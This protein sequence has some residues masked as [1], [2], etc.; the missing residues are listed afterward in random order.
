MSAVSSV[1][2]LKPLPITA[3]GWCARLHANDVSEA[4]RAAF[5]TWVAAST[6]NRAEYELCALTFGVARALPASR[7][8]Y[9][10]AIAASLV[11]VAIGAALAIWHL[12]TIQYATDVG[13]H[14]TI[15][16]ADGSTV[17]L[18]T[19][20]AIGVQLS[21]LQR[22]VT[23]RRGEAFFS[24]VPDSARPFVVQA[25]AS[26]VRVLGTRFNV[27]MEGETARV[28]VIE[29]HVKVSNVDLLPGEGVVTM[30]AR[31][32]TKL[33]EANAAKLTSWREGK[34][35]FE[36]D[37]LAKVIGEVNRYSDIQFV[38]P[39]EKVRALTLSGVFRTGDI[40]SVAFALEESYG[41]KTE[42]D[43]RRILVKPAS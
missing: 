21:E 19:A 28:T 8:R 16:L 22:R 39:D 43:G 17:E 9:I 35:H 26:E 23:L 34:I 13:E 7:R 25:G 10:P 42:R 20:S 15:S 32:L 11:L 1:V 3:E 31:P 2:E 27:R 30:P 12:S 14:R 29:G 4:E 37:P 38:I 6:D 36:N 18:N 40:D 24:V 41:L 5:A 33:R